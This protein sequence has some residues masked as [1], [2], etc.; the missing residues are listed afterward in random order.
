MKRLEAN[1]FELILSEATWNNPS[2]WTDKVEWVQR[3]FG[4]GM[5]SMFYKHIILCYHKEICI[6][7][8]EI[9]YVIGYLI[10]FA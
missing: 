3:E 1:G 8:R 10:L 6:S 9:T 5:Y 7:K 2:A 4:A